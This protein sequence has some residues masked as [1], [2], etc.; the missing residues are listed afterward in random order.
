MK[1]K[2][3]ILFG[4][5]FSLLFVVSNAAAQDEKPKTVN[6]GVVNGKAEKLVQPAYPPAARAIKASGAVNVQVSIDEEGNVSSATA[7][8][9]HPLLRQASEKAALASKFKPTIL[10]GKA[11][12]ATGIVVYNF[13]IDSP[14]KEVKETPQV[15][16]E[17]TYLN[18]QAVK[19]VAPEYPAA[20]RAVRASGKVE[21]EVTIDEKGNV[22]R[23]E[24]VSGHPLLRQASEK[25]ARSSKFEPTL[26][27]GQPSQI[28]G[29]IVYNFAIPPKR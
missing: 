18:S 1:A 11:V 23:A 16:D 29:I 6:L 14:V 21:V 3:F 19:L 9:G 5:L 17:K 8:S 10:S 20:A 7:V 22:T 13:V 15:E 2:T 28:T 4:V 27:D 24:T 26:V 25:A 12:R